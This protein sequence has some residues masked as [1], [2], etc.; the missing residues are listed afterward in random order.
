M[1]F[2]LCKLKSTELGKYF[3][4]KTMYSIAVAGAFNSDVSDELNVYCNNDEQVVAIVDKSGVPHFLHILKSGNCHGRDVQ[5]LIDEV[6]TNYLD[7]FMVR[8]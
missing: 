6:S 7:G 3:G 5:L 2:Y 1:G 4:S 8:I